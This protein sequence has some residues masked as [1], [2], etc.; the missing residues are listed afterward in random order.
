MYIPQIPNPK[1]PSWL[2]PLKN[3]QVVS[4]FYRET[5]HFHL[6][7]NPPS[8][9]A[10]DAFGQVDT[11]DVHLDFSALEEGIRLDNSEHPRGGWCLHLIWIMWFHD[12]SVGYFGFIASF[13]GYDLPICWC[14]SLLYLIR[15]VFLAKEKNHSRNP[16]YW[17]LSKSK[18]AKE[19][20][21]YPYHVNGR[22][23]GMDP[24]NILDRWVVPLPRNSHH[25][26]YYIHD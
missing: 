4:W 7:W 8:W 24:S 5:T 14:A 22:R 18:W 2:W 13:L 6:W 12:V 20:N 23:I 25:Q 9:Q 10:I 19:K 11:I 26:D 15:D 17:I 3:P 1:K 21:K 16:N